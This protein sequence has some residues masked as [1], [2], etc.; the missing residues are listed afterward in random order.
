[1][2]IDN[3]AAIQ[4]VSGEVYAARHWQETRKLAGQ[5]SDSKIRPLALL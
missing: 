4:V 5:Q 2:S 1:M 3:F